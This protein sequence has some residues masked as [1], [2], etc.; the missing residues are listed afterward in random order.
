MANPIVFFDF[1]IDGKPAG[2]VE[3]ELYADKCPKAAENF[4]ALCTGEKGIGRYGSPLHYKGTAI[5]RLYAGTG[6]MRGGIV[7]KGIFEGVESIYGGK[8]EGD[9]ELSGKQLDTPGI[10]SLD[11]IFSNSSGKMMVTTYFSITTKAIDDKTKAISPGLTPSY[12]IGHVVNGLDVLNN[13]LTITT[14]K[15]YDSPTKA[16]IVADCGQII[17]G[18]VFDQNINTEVY[19][20]IAI[21]G[22][23]F[24]RIIMKLFYDTTPRT[25]KN[26]RALCTSGKLISNKSRKYLHYRG[27]TFHRV[28]P[29]VMC[30]GGDFSLENGTGGDCIDGAHSFLIGE[31]FVNKH[32]RPGIL[33]MVN[34]G[35]GADGSQFYICTLECWIA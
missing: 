27:S 33:S 21:G 8:F 34:S 6:Y 9:D 4:R 31:R 5:D 24:G 1:T 2:R 25:A 13:I 20:D 7:A 18:M 15:E 32:T 23:P 14:S 10:L 11:S 30:H 35:K 17:S 26:F 3:F 16:V 12:V 19:F 29:G 22:T 28:I